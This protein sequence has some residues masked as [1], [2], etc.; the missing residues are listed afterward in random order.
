MVSENEVATNVVSLF[1]RKNKMAEKVGNE[2]QEDSSEFF[3]AI[4]RKNQQVKER[5][6]KDRNKANRS[7]LRSYRIK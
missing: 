3:D 1:E 4:V 7:V 6:K 5:M 2:T